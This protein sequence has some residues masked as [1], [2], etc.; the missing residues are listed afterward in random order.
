MHE[1]I[2]DVF[3]IKES[4]ILDSLGRAIVDLLPKAMER[5]EEIA[6]K[7]N[8]GELNRARIIDGKGY[9]FFELFF[10]SRE[11]DGF[12]ID[13]NSGLPLPLYLVLDYP[14]GTVKIRIESDAYLPS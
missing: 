10:P 8:L 12:K 14:K 6:E 13:G 1:Q 3:L 7:R 5:G 4:E 9:T 2:D 11:T